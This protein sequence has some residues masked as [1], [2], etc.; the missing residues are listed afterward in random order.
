MVAMVRIIAFAV[1][2]LASC[3]ALAQNYAGT[4][5]TTNPQGGTV[6]LTLRNDGP[7]QVKGT[8]NGNNATFE[9]AGEV[10][11]QGLMG[12]VTGP[13]GNLYMMAQYEGANL[14]VILAEP[15]PNG[16]P[17]VESA[18][19]IVFAKAGSGSPKPGAA[20]PAAPGGSDAQ[21]SQ[22]LTRNA[23]CGFTFNQRSGTSSTERI[24]FDA[25]GTVTQSSGR[26][27]YS[28]GASG[29]VAGQY[30]GGQQ[31]RWKVADGAL[32]LSQDGVNWQPQPLQITQNS[33][34]S[35][36]VK[37]GGKEYMVCR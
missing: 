13:Q 30:S 11:P 35:P 24:V 6:T 4:F 3:Y 9:V 18:R 31:A 1:A 12:A 7:K 15:G 19:R 5:T 14:V 23:W 28:S 25:N 26:E 34:G 32:H 36:I 8:L 20:A 29:S 21:L 22:F 16:Q 17:N 27:T 33:N 2:A 10:T 37:S